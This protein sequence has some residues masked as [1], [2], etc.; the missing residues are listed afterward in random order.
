MR[1]LAC[2]DCGIESRRQ[3][4]CLSTVSVVCCQVQVSATGRSLVQRSP[5]EC[6]VSECDHET[7]TMR[8]VEPYKINWLVGLLVG[9]W[10]I[11]LLR[12]LRTQKFT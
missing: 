3:H 9:C 8:A 10:L 5:T 7:S 11:W 6:G 1:Q 2:C 12:W 4:G